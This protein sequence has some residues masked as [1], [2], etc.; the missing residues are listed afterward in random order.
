ML[1]PVVGL[2]GLNRF[3]RTVLDNAGRAIAGM[4]RDFAPPAPASVGEI[5]IT[6]FGSTTPCVAHLAAALRGAGLEPVVFHANGVG[7][8][9]LEQWLTRGEFSAVLDVT[10]TE[11]ADEL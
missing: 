4:A 11:L 1:F 2:A 8:C 6:M 10:T 5:A 3:S 9:A 7:G